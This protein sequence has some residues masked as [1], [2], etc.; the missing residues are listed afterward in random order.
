MPNSTSQDSKTSYVRYWYNYQMGSYFNGAM[1]RLKNAIEK[2]G[3][4]VERTMAR[5]Q[6]IT[7]GL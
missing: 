3:S 4:G 6:G 7:R 1:R 5:K 2:P